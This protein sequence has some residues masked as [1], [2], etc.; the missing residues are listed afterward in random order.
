MFGYF[1]LIG[2][3][4]LHTLTSDYYM[5]LKTIECI[6]LDVT[7]QN[8]VCQVFHCIVAT[9]YHAG[10]CYSMMR[11]YEDAIRV[12]VDTLLY[13]QRSKPIMVAQTFQNDA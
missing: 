9:N 10:F 13:I 1:S 3:L 11:N 7:K 4:K 8:D 6:D 2:L 5:A 12:F